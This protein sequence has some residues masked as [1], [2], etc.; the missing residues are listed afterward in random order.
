MDDRFLASFVCVVEHGS[1][2]EAARHLNLTPAGVGQRI[3]ALEAEVGVVLVARV[4]R[5][6]R[7]TAAGAAIYDRARNIQK[8][9]NDLKS[10]AASGLLSGEL[11]LGVAPTLLSGLVP[12]LICS[13]ASAHPRIELRVTRDNSTDLY[14]KIL[15]GQIDAAITSHPSFTIPKTCAW[16]LL[17]EEPFVVLT[18]AAMPPAH[19]HAL[20]STEPFIRLDRRVYAGQLIDSFLRKS[21]IRP[22]ERLEVDGPEA[23]AIMVDRGLGITLLPDWAPPWPEGLKL[24]KIPLPHPLLRRRIGLLWQRASLRE[25]VIR[26][27]VAEALRVLGKKAAPSKRREAP[28]RGLTDRRGKSAG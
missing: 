12:D 27:F 16:V 24:Q 20:L 19:P 13:F 1:I 4:G 15:S 21:G 3:R 28:K 7:P 14:N 8:Q 9:I 10:V 22:H 23:I 5:R 2:A 6:V 17:R 11:R 25:G 26:A 18:P